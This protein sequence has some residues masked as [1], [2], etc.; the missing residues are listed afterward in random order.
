[1]F[2]SVRPICTFFLALGTISSPAFSPEKAPASAASFTKTPVRGAGITFYET[3]NCMDIGLAPYL[4][5]ES[6]RTTQYD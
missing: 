6:G 2:L 3:T 1:M 4:I 5:P